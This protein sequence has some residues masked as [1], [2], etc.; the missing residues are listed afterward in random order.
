MNDVE[1]YT[2]VFPSVRAAAA[3]AGI[4]TEML[5]RMRR[6]GYVAT[7][8]RALRMAEACGHRVSAAGLLG[9]G[10]ADHRARAG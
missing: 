10:Q 1:R 7:R 9:L 2:A 6:Q 5:R 8:E 4:S 3:A